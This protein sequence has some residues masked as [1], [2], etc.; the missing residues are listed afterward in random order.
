MLFEHDKWGCTDWREDLV[1]AR[2]GCSSSMTKRVKQI[3]ERVC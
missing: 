1:R 3:S 2:F